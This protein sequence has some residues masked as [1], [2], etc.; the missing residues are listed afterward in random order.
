MGPLSKQDEGQALA[1]VPESVGPEA[2]SVD[3]KGVANPKAVD[4]GDENV[5]VA[6]E[7]KQ[8][9]ALGNETAKD[10][11]ENPETS[12]QYV[13]R[14]LTE[15]H[16]FGDAILT[17][18][19][20]QIGQV[21]LTMPN[22]LWKTGLKAGLISSLVSMLI[23]A[24]TMYMLA[25]LFLE[26]KRDLIK[27]GE[28][29]NANGLRTRV[30]QYH[31]VIGHHMGKP[32][33][34]FSQIVVALCIGGTSLA[35]IIACAGDVYAID[36][37]LSKRTWGLIWGAVLMLFAFVPNFR[38]F[39]VLN[40]IALIGT[41]YTALY[42]VITVSM[43]GRSPAADPDRAPRS[44]QLYFNGAAVL[45]NALGGHSIALEMMDSMRNQTKFLGA[46]GFGW[47]WSLLLT[48]PHS[49][50]VNLVYPQAIGKNDNVFGLLPVNTGLKIAAWL[51][52]V[53]QFVA[54]ALY[55]TPLLYMFE[56][57]CGVHEKSLWL[58]YLVRLPV[59][60]FIYFLGIMLPFY[61]SI[62][63]FMGAFGAPL[64][65]FVLPSLTFNWVF[66]TKA[67]RA[68][69]VFPPSRPFS[70]YNWNVAIF[71]NCIIFVAYLGFWGGAVYY[72]IKSIVDNAHTFGLFAECY[73]CPANYKKLLHHG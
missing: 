49:V 15:G 21:M 73:Q 11:L 31:E 61:S 41:S 17:V 55:C 42:I 54:F 25:A 40:V 45:I 4:F 39:R 22:A 29:Y 50:A 14:V 58:R 33:Q 36:K 72:A 26:R 8:K 16:T 37:T 60:L 51:M 66:R 71:I 38:H 63:A 48:I 2:F 28:W 52:V 64:T 24:W 27:R 57:L 34:I 46:F 19:A 67:R 62:N 56:K 44:T 1:R 18:A 12:L 53:H 7:L 69:A 9:I 5:G 43:K 68:T 30:S 65:A 70:Y 47:V 6:D 10:I 59:A 32:L 35:Q 20:A 23:S 3:A 13:R